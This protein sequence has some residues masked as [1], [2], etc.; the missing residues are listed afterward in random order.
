MATELGTAYI[1]IIP[2]ARGIGEKL[3][4]E[5]GGETRDSGASAG[6]LFGGSL[7]KS[8]VGVFAAAAIGK[9]VATSLTEGAALQQSLGGVETLFKNN[10]D[11]VKNYASQAYKTAGVSAN[12]Y[13]ENVT[14]FSASLISSLGGDT[15]K[16][17]ELAN[18]AMVDMSDNANK[19]GTDMES[20]T[21]TYQSLA[22]GNYAMLDNLKLGYG[23]TKSEM[24][25][26]M[27]DAEKL[28]GEHYTVGDF[29]DTVK[30][31]HAVQDSMGITGTTAKE[32]ATTFSGSFASMKAAFADFM[33]N[34]SIGADITPSLRALGES[35]STFI[36]GNL[37]PML[38]NIVKA[39]PTVVW[40]IISDI[41]NAI[42]SIDFSTLLGNIVS[43]LSDIASVG[44]DIINKV[45]EGITNGI[46]S[47]LSSISDLVPQIVS[48]WE[49]GFKDLLTIGTDMVQ[50][51]FTGIQG[52]LP[53][54]SEEGRDMIDFFMVGV[55]EGLPNLLETSY[56]MISQVINSWLESLPS[57]IELGADFINSLVEGFLTTAPMILETLTNWLGVA[58]D[59]LLTFLPKMLEMGAQYIVNMATGIVQ[60]LPQIG[61]KAIQAVSQ[62][63]DTILQ[64]GPRFLTSGFQS[65]VQFING[66]I[67]KLPDVLASAVRI[68]VTLV[69]GIVQNLPS[70]ISTAISLMTQFV[71]ML[72]SKIPNVI[73]AGAK[74]LTGFVQGILSIIGNL[75]SAIGRIASS[76]TGGLTNIDL[77]GAGKA[78]IDGFING[79]KSTWE[80]AKNFI[81]GIAKWI[82][83]HKGP[84]EYDRVLLKPHGKAIMTGFNDSMMET[85]KTVQKNVSG[86]AGG[87]SD[88]FMDNM[89]PLEAPL[90]VTSDVS[91]NTNQSDIQSVLDSNRKL[92]QSAESEGAKQG[93]T[94]NMNITV[95]GDSEDKDVLAERIAGR[96]E[97][98]IVR[99]AMA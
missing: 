42:A 8:A 30:A 51:I 70:L 55:I 83:D 25:R 72:I 81:G 53:D 98:I 68:V 24:Q 22:R 69:T 2:S 96:V 14:A 93:D 19:M 26:L 75:V 52:A 58:I 41:G 17:A 62:F 76:L 43:G 61:Q 66:I 16:A 37:M 27:K 80:G 33:G 84:I 65:I 29:A 64:N 57:V 11:T 12:K 4:K 28:T 44:S 54:I 95:N 56:E 23:G 87:I 91:F 59:G 60:N 73:S 40:T 92:I 88:L 77:F 39:I 13:M 63:A 97:R 32:A 99:R 38:W 79:I 34:L 18:T 31:I 71:S 78:I 67:Q 5:V 90:N 6:K 82:S 15:K 20:V 10:A 36:F 94:F 3:K 1:Q 46:P 45:V 9:A 21:Q 47:L 48:G 85:F 35:I 89:G 49:Q 74:V 86:M 50:N 7:V